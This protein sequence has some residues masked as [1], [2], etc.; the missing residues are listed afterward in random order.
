MTKIK[1]KELQK[2]FNDKIVSKYQRDTT[3]FTYNKIKNLLI[4]RLETSYGG[5][6]ALPFLLDVC[7]FFKVSHEAVNV[8]ADSVSWAYSEY[9]YGT[10]SYL[11]IT[12][13]LTK[14]LLYKE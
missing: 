4:I 9:T 11:N 8:E 14:S 12:V 10:D 5:I 2:E 6:P 3:S 13:D 1:L 7:E